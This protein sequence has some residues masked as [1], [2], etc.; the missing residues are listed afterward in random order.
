MNRFKLLNIFMKGTVGI[1]MLLISFMLPAQN[2]TVKGTVVDTNNEPIVGATIVIRGQAARGTVT[3]F[4]GNY[5]LANVPSNAILEIS[6]VGMKKEVIPLN[7]RTTI[8]VVLSED[9]EVLEELVVTGY[10]TQVRSQMT[11][12]V[13]KLN[14]KVLESASRSNAA[15]A[16]QGTIPGLRVTQ[17]TGQPGTT[18][19]LLLRGGTGFDGSGSP[20]ILIDGVPGAFYAL[21]ADDIESIEVLKDAASTA[22]Y[23]A[24][25]ANG[26][27]IVTTKKGKTGK[28]SINFRAKYTFNDPSKDPMKYL[29]A[30]DYVRFNRMAVM[31]SRMVEN[32]PNSWKAFLEGNNAAATGNNALNSIYTTM[33]LTENNKYLLNH[34]GWQTI[35]DPVTGKD[36]I[37]QENK[38]NE[39]FYQDSHTQDYSLSFDGGND[40]GTYYLGLG[41]MDDNGLVFGSNFKRISGTVNASY[42][43]TDAFKIS[44]SMI[45][46]HSNQALPFDEVYNLFQRCAG[47]AP[48]SRIYNNNPDGSLSDELQPGTYLGFGNP[49]YYRDKFPKSNLEQR[50]TASVQFDYKF[51]NDFILTVRGSHFTF[52]DSKESFNKAFISSGKLNTE[53]QAKVSHERQLRNQM[54]AILNYKKQI[55]HNNVAAL[56]G[57]EYFRE[58]VFKFSAATRYSPTDLIYTMNVGAEASGVPSSSRTEYAIA[59]LFGQV[60]YDYDYRYLAGLTF[61]YDGTSRLANKKYGFFPGISAGWNAHNEAFFKESKVRNVISKLKPRISYGVNGNIEVLSNF[62]VFGVYGPLLDDNGKPKPT[63]YDTQS[64]YLNTKLP[65]LDLMWERSTTLNFGLDLGL[66]NNRIGIM[67]DYFIRDVQDK[68]ADL[69]LPLWT[70][71][72]KILTNNGTLQNRGL[73]IELTADVIDTKDFKWN[74]GTTFFRVRNYAK[75][76]PDNGVEKNRQ[77]GTEIY[78]P[79]TGET[80]YVGGLQEGERVGLDVITAYLF[81]GVYQTQAEIDADKDRTVEF[82]WNKKKRFLGDTRWKDINGDNVIN[83]LDRVVIGRTTPKFSGG[84]TTNLTYKGLDLF[85]KGD[86]TVGHYLMNGRRVKGIAQTQG[87]QNGPREI[88]DSWT[89]DNPTSKI[90]RFDLVDRQKNH[91]AAGWD[92]GDMTNGSSRYIEKGDYFALREVTLS[93]NLP[94]ISQYMNNVR[95][96][97]TATN[98]AY[99]S[100]YTGALPEEAEKMKDGQD[101]GRYPLPKSYTIGLNITF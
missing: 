81:D 19:K 34:E 42:K 15:T 38:M 23:G 14:T 71:F 52:N 7:G 91:L 48:T 95:L 44:S 47:L 43:I 11:T 89:Q 26:V 90:P 50:L 75:K 35:K 45:Y 68:L 53:R 10:S 29:G 82:A 3:D 12:A 76:L 57:A 6:F 96:Y 49:L 5:V 67:A 9:T 20:L 92:Q 84:V 8:H 54:T 72:S 22:I 25:A 17:T 73:E 83:Y 62:G 24:R 27:V 100:G 39:L 63:I 58:N 1:V 65:T 2:V 4:E 97:F 99:F 37:F 55:T 33:F 51:L 61:R 46:A 31:N 41:Y 98:L 60:N 80:K 88:R 70:G 101:T 28:S 32:N 87:N 40:K 30:A 18:P 21:N 93:Y 36:L 13:S 64:G 79:K 56:L 59:S 78:D 85:I 74:V 66:C 94:R 16:L 77:G 69:T 86:Y